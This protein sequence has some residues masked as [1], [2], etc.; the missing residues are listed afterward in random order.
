MGK[1]ISTLFLVFISLYG[2][3][4]GI[5][6]HGNVNDTAAGQP[7]PN[8]LLM[9]IR[10]SD[11][12][13]V[14][15]TRTDAKGLLK[16]LVIPPDTYIVILS[17]PNFNDKT[18][19]LV[20]SPRD[21][22]FYFRNVQ[23][24]P[25][26]VQLKEVEVI[27]FK[28]KTYYKGDTLVFTADS[29]KTRP[30]ATVED[31]LKKLPGVRVDA[32]GKITIQGKEVDQVL[33]DGDEFFGND[34]TMATR[35]L[36]ANAVENVQVFDKKNE[37]T[38]EGANETLKVVNLKLKEDAKKGYFGKL[39]GATDFN[40][41][42]ENEGLFNAFK[43]NR[44]LSLFTI[45]A[46]TPKQAFNWNDIN[47]YGLD[48][49]EAWSYDDE[50]G[51]WWSN[52]E[53]KT[54]VPRTI[55]TGMYYS[56]KL[57]KNTKLSGDYSFN[58]NNLQVGKQTNT[59]YFL[60]DTS[61]T[62]ASV[63][64][65]SMVNQNHTF[66][67]K[68]TQK[69]DSL[70]DL[71][72]IPKLNYKTSSGSTYQSDE[73]ISENS[74]LT[75]STSVSSKNEGNSSGM[76][77]S[78]KL[79]K[80]FK[81]KDRNLS[82]TYQ[83]IYNDGSS[84][85]TQQTDYRYLLGQKPDSVFIQ[86]RRLSNYKIEHNAGIVYTEPLSKKFKVEV[87]YNFSQNRSNNS[88]STSDFTTGSDI[89][90]PVL[91]NSFEN[92]RMMNRAGASVIYDVKKM[93]LVIGSYLRTIHQEN[94]NLSSNE[95]LQY[96]FNNILPKA[97]F[98]Y[99][100]AQSSQLH[101]NYRSSSQ[102]PD[103]KQMQPVADYSDPNNVVIGNPNLK[104]TFS[105]NVDINYYFYKGI[106]DVNL[107]CG[108]NVNTTNNQISTST[109]Y[110]EQGRSVSQSV[111]INGNYY[112]NLWVGGGFPLF[113][114]FMK[115]NPGMN[116]NYRNNV[117]LVNNVTNVTTNKGVG[118]YLN[119]EKQKEKY[120]VS[121]NGEYSYEMPKNNLSALSSQPYYTYNFGS[122][123]MVK[124]PLKFGI[125]TDVKYTNNGK[126]AAGY[127]ISYVIWNAA[128]RKTFTK[129]ENLIVSFEANDLL[130]QNISNQRFASG[131]QIVDTKTNIIKRY[132]LL[133]VLLKLNSQ[134]TKEEENDY[135]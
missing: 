27:A 68:L 24:P 11:S 56:D 60:T 125:E 32:K 95:K 121:L 107:Y 14:N 116:A 28:E 54:G 112:T 23:L 58:Q 71:I 53:Q 133:K 36:N 81:K 129:R 25:R 103:L 105:N 127:N 83:P 110:D 99:R 62:D 80:N 13:L 92:R 67:F 87:N 98:V 3:A 106:S 93:R 104:P 41:F 29:F 108:A 84:K 55:K 43:G 123:V 20:G 96:T 100:F 48:N 117:S 34:P 101:M 91:S 30:N 4:Q 85:Y 114:R 63:N 64:Q 79:N 134:K 126:R 51:M 10:F 8:V 65:A 86:K 37:N 39:S 131:N 33:V 38:S 77:L 128:V 31:L 89:Y 5:R 50:S 111:N 35:N 19:L 61:Y 132:F 70:T 119:L 130:N 22:A 76:D 74:V 40:K 57:G 1:K 47:K 82:L 7:L 120:E 102:Q 124:L 135:D 75:R 12:T 45:A 72:V 109:S 16:P 118:F 78:L 52:N 69:L 97:G 17:H 6:L 15:Y 9:A 18:Y 88:R 73:F 42:Y 46:N 122:S 115:V 113:K 94:L 49:E 66:N 21:T 2:F 59:Q 44:K 90:N 26:S